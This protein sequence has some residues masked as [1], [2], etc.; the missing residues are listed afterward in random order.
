VNNNYTPEQLRAIY[1]AAERANESLGVELHYM[2]I[3]HPHRQRAREL[4]QAF[5]ADDFHAGRYETSLMLASDPDL[6]DEDRRAAL[7]DLRIDLVAKIRDGQVSST[8]LGAEQAY[9]GF[10]A[11]A[12]AEEGE[13]AYA[14]LCAMVVQAAEDMLAGRPASGPGW[15]ARAAGEAEPS[16]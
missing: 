4:P 1:D 6:V 2:D 14:N 12:S 9:I 7:P 16:P 11:A 13:A 15:Y 8:E 5:V 10:P 3:T